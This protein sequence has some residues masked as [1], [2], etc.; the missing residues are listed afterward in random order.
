MTSRRPATTSAP[1]VVPAAS[2]SGSAAPVSPPKSPTTTALAATRFVGEADTSE[3]P[4]IKRGGDDG[5]ATTSQVIKP[6]LLKV[7]VHGGCTCVVM[8]GDGVCVTTVDAGCSLSPWM[9]LKIW[10][11]LTRMI[12]RNLV[13][14]VL[15]WPLSPAVLTRP[16]CLLPVPGLCVLLPPGTADDSSATVFVWFSDE[17]A[18]PSDAEASDVREFAKAVAQSYASVHLRGKS[19]TVQVEA[20]GD[21]SDEFWEVFDS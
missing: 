13:G 6:R 20:G 4:L 7:G 11:C 15:L 17:F 10:A 3:A 12:W 9:P 19:F 1:T 18:V 14:A 2:A 8:C 16:R 21:E 5:S